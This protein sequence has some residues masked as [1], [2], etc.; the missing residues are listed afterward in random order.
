MRADGTLLGSVHVWRPLQHRVGKRYPLEDWSLKALGIG[1]FAIEVC[2]DGWKGIRP[3]SRYALAGAKILCNP[4]ASWFTIG[5]QKIRRHMVLQTSRED[6]C[7]YAY[8]SLMGCDST[9]LIFDG[10][11]F[12]AEAGEMLNEGNR[13]VFTED[14]FRQC[15]NRGCCIIRKGETGD[16]VVETTSRSVASRIVWRGTTTHFCRR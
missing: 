5:K 8:T 1:K 4:S 11:S 14:I 16:G 2:E 13:F 9:R 6:M 15:C 12:I 3:G 7:A 10:A